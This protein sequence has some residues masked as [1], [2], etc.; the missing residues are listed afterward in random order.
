MREQHIDTARYA[1]RD[2]TGWHH[3]YFPR[4]E[5]PGH[6]RAEA[7]GWEMAVRVEKNI[8]VMLQEAYERQTEEVMDTLEEGPEGS[9]GCRS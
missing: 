2:A 4:L 1:L 7:G 3:D 6:R 5:K 9:Y 8:A